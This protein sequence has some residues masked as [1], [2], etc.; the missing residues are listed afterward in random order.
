MQ[1]AAVG[2]RDLYTVPVHVLE[3]K[4]PVEINPFF[5]FLSASSSNPSLSHFGYE[6]MITHK[7]N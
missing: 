3:L 1:I 5:V 7:H 2:D 4:N 6:L